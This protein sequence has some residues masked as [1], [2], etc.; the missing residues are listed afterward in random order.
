MF[1]H[2]AVEDSVALSSNLISLPSSPLTM[3][4]LSTSFLEFSIPNFAFFAQVENLLFWKDGKMEP[5]P[6]KSQFPEQ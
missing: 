2:L 1:L 4:T 5:K 6:D 3:Y